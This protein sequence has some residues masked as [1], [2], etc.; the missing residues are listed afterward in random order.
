MYPKDHLYKLLR[1]GIKQWFELV[2][3]KQ[4][5]SVAYFRN[6][7]PLSGGSIAHPHSQIVGFDKYNYLEK[8]N[9]QDFEGIIID[10]NSDV[11]FNLSTKPRVGFYEF[12]VILKDL[13][14]I[15]QFADYIQRVAHYILNRFIF[16]CNSY[17]VFFYN[18]KDQIIA[19]IIPRFVTSPLYI[20]YAI[21]QVPNNLE[22][23]LRD[24]T[25]KYM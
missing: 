16:R 23:V 12:N 17:N 1:F 22:D 6:Y 25:T 24:F 14:A 21:P 15:P 20:G 5:T 19:K 11:V 7:G 2:D 9:E 4:F 10:Q 3:S 8:I 18:Y 13:K